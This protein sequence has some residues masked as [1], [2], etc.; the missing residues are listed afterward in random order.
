MA[1]GS[2]RFLV[3]PL[4]S[5]ERGHN[6]LVGQE[7]AIG[8]VYFLVRPYPI[9]G[10][11]HA[12]IHKLNAWGQTYVQTL[13]HSPGNPGRSATSPSLLLSNGKMLLEKGKPIKSWAIANELHCFGLNLSW[14]GNAL[15]VFYEEVLRPV[16]HFVDARWAENSPIGNKDTEKNSMLLGFQRILQQATT[17]PD[18]VHRAIATTLYGEAA[19]AFSNIQ[20]VYDV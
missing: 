6:I 8:S 3:A 10:D 4:Q 19:V 14:F 20:G 12:A 15:A 9:P 16:F 18:P 13:T 11:I 5:I 17:D 7:A 1:L 2:A